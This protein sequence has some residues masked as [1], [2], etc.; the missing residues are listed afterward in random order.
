M[1]RR[2]FHGMFDQRTENCRQATDEFSIPFDF[3][4]SFVCFGSLVVELIATFGIGALWVKI[5]NPT[6][7]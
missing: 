7:T 2:R 1:Q 5:L 6:L 3:D 4:V